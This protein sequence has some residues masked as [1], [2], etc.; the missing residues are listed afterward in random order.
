MRVCKGYFAL[1]IILN[2]TKYHSMHR[3]TLTPFL[4]TITKGWCG[5]QF[6]QFGQFPGPVARYGWPIPRRRLR[7]KVWPT[8]RSRRATVWLLSTRVACNSLASF[9]MGLR[10][11]NWTKPP[12]VASYSL[13]HSI[14]GCML[15]FEQHHVGCAVLTPPTRAAS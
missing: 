8:P 2:K 15:Q 4:T 3:L 9:Q 1:K 5:L 13:T 11:S 12:S 7:A 10:A 14:A 6:G